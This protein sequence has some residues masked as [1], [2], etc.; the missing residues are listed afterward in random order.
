MS[1]IK[2][3]DIG[4]VRLRAPDL[5]EM[6]RFLADFGLQVTDATSGRLFARGAG[7]APFLHATELGDPGFAALGLRAESLSDLEVLAKAE[8]VEI[9][10]L[11]APGGGQM[12]VL[13]DPDGHRIEV[14]AG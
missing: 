12:V 6:S 11:D 13:S 14:V 3:E 2:I 1:L 4:Y 5:D 9:Q 10:P 8:G 7:T